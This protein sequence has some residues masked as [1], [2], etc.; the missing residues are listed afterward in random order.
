[1]PPEPTPSA[2][3]SAPRR[4]ERPLCLPDRAGLCATITV[5]G[6]LLSVGT[7]AGDDDLLATVRAAHRSARESIRTISTNVRIEATSPKP[8]L[9]LE[10]SYQRKFDV[11]RA[12]ARTAGG[13]SDYLVIGAE[14]RQLN[15]GPKLPNGQQL[16]DAR[17]APRSETIGLADVWQQMLIEFTGMDGRRYDFDGLLG[18]A[19]RPPEARRE[20]AGGVPCVRVSVTV[21]VPGYGEFGYVLWHDIGRNYLVR[22]MAFTYLDPSSQFVAENVEFAE[23]EPGVFVPTR[24][25]RRQ[26]AG[27]N[28]TEFATILADLTVNQPIPDA[29][30]RLPPVTPG[31][32]VSDL[33]HGTTYPINGLWERTGP[34]K[35]LV[36]MKVVQSSVEGDGSR[37]QSDSETW[38]AGWWV[39]PTAVVVLVLASCSYL[40]RRYRQPDD[41]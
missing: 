40:Y 36:N 32:E 16:H 12:Q 41:A 30:F 13:T 19:K 3:R 15:A 22:K 24:C 9:V 18:L 26:S 8:R 38:R 37:S 27:G 17:R 29:V 20:R 25:L 2:G 10:G 39:L 6:W 35:P 33:V 28:S 21:E 4:R 31:T 5:V 14:V 7:C 23:P 34:A 11:V 1:M